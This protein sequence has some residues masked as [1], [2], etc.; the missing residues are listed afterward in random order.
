M[1]EELFKDYVV[2][3]P[4]GHEYLAYE[5]EEL[6]VWL[7]YLKHNAE[8]SLHCHPNKKTSL[9]LL[10]GKAEISFITSKI[11]A[12][13]LFKIVIWDRVFH[14]TKALSENGIYVF[15]I[16]TPKDKG[17]LVRVKDK[18]GRKFKPYE[19]EKSLVKKTDEC[20]WMEDGGNYTFCNK[21]ISIES[22]TKDD[23]IAN[24]GDD[25]I[26][27]LLGGNIF[28]E[29]GDKLLMPGDAVKGDAF[30]K[31]IKEFP[32]KNNLLLLRIKK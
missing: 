15:E 19:D 11:Q 27:A 13:E 4:W 12:N 17:D 6:S 8:T 21:N 24:I 30:K 29:R 7:L 14:S 9:I 3:K 10:D 28:S 5:N 20:L 31:F 32:Y 1:K 22:V 18:Y 2:K 16:E 23:E 26:I 25:E